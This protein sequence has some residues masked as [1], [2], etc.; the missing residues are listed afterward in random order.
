M[1]VMQVREVD[2][3]VDVVWQDKV[4]GEHGTAYPVELLRRAARRSFFGL[5]R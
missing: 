3:V 4:G 5:R 2:G 1:T